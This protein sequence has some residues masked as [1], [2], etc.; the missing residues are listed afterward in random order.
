MA[1]A[2]G[3]TTFKPTSDRVALIEQPG[4]LPVSREPHSAASRAAVFVSDFVNSY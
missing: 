2:R 1:P 3:E 4:A